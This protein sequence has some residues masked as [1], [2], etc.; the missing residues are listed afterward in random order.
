MDTLDVCP[1]GKLHSE[2]KMGNI[3]RIHKTKHEESENQYLQ[4]YIRSCVTTFNNKH[5]I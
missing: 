2:R 5:K 4:D 1:H 3:Y